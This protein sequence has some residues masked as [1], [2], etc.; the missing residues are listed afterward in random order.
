MRVRR[1]SARGSIRELRHGFADV[2]LWM[3]KKGYIDY[4]CPQVYF[5]FKHKTQAFDKNVDSW[6]K[7]PAQ[8]REAVHRAWAV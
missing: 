7:C 2:E 8:Q 1:Q 5:G 6:L 3:S 4:V